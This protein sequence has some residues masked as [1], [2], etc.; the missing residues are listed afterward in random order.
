MND[1]LPQPGRFEGVLGGWVSHHR[2]DH[3][4]TQ[5]EDAAVA[6]GELTARATLRSKPVI[7]DR[8]DLISALDQL[9][10]LE[11]PRLKPASG[12]STTS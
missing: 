10:R 2:E 3:S 6:V 12:S 8:H 1:L 9:Q 5:G 4:V 11:D 7:D